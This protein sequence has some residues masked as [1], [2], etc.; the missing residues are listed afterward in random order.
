[1]RSV[2]QELPENCG[3]S[4]KARRHT[5]DL[6]LQKQPLVSGC[7]EK[8]VGRAGPVMLVALIG[9][10]KC[11][12]SKSY[13]KFATL[14]EAAVERHLPKAPRV[15]E[16]PPSSVLYGFA[17]LQ[18]WN[19]VLTPADAVGNAML[20]SLRSECRRKHS[21]ILFQHDLKFSARLSEPMT[22][23]NESASGL[24]LWHACE[25]SPLHLFWHDRGLLQ[26]VP[27]TVALQGQ[28]SACGAEVHLWP[29]FTPVALAIA[30]GALRSDFSVLVERERTPHPLGW[31]HPI[32]PSLSDLHC[33]RNSQAILEVPTPCSVPR[34]QG[35]LKSRDG[36][37][38]EV[39]V[40]DV[41]VSA[42]MKRNYTGKEMEKHI[43]EVEQLQLLLSGGVAGACTAA[44]PAKRT[45]PLGKDLRRQNFVRLDIAA[46]LAHRELYRSTGPFFRMLATDKSGQ[47]A[48]SWEVL[49]TCEVTI[50]RSAVEGK[51]LEEILPGDIVRRK[52]VPCCLSKDGTDL[53]NCVWSVQHQTWLDYGPTANSLKSAN[54]DV[55][56]LLTDLGTEA[57]IVDYFDI[58]DYYLACVRNSPDFEM[59][60]VPLANDD[61]C[62][63]CALKTIGPLHCIDWIIE[64]AM[65]KIPEFPEYLKHCKLM[66][67]HMHGRN[68]RQ[69]MKRKIVRSA[70]DPEEPERKRRCCASLKT[71]CDRFADWRWTSLRSCTLAIDRFEDP[72]R[73]CFDPFPPLVT[74]R[75][76]ANALNSLR[77]SVT[78]PQIFDLNRA[79]AHMIEPLMQLHGWIKGCWCHSAEEH[80]PPRTLKCVFQGMRA[81]ELASRVRE[82]I[83]AYEQLRE[84]LFLGQFG[85]TSCSGLQNICGFIIA[86][87]VLKLLK[88]L[89]DIPY[90]LW[91][92]LARF[93]ISSWRYCCAFCIRVLKHLGVCLLFTP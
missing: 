8:G 23:E 36:F 41:I 82:T 62:Y 26:M 5:P 59:S 11:R 93:W 57:G 12:W 68:N 34:L 2:T 61:H 39:K 32:C 60:M 24:A 13:G 29:V 1:M 69:D 9:H 15:L 90:L 16:N 25:Q 71:G 52:L 35:F 76:K 14:V 87:L 58:A 92:D 31:K 28:F 40:Q 19:I 81:K 86:M 47:S 78:S 75:N 88:W 21:P 67:Q 3:L 74:R 37:S 46:M 65:C 77:L 64:K 56:N 33:L 30:C 63:P 91:Q 49:N 79:V 50:R 51:T 83:V 7:A 80:R 27:G 18:S 89:N 42:D 17:A 73:M 38:A 53:P 45:R 6:P 43:E 44:A 70:T 66:L 22:I 10:G 84:S 72:I 85:E 54:E 48:G 4:A 20:R 55:R